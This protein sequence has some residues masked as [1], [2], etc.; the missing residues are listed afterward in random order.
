MQNLS[1]STYGPNNRDSSI[2]MLYRKTPDDMYIQPS[3]NGMVMSFKI[4]PNEHESPKQTTWMWGMSFSKPM[5]V[6]AFH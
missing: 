4:P 6:V 3:S 5:W 2:Q 1:F